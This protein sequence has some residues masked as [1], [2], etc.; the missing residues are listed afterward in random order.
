MDKDQKEAKIRAEKKEKNFKTA[1][2][3]YEFN[4]MKK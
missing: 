2:R 4:S 1:L 3:K